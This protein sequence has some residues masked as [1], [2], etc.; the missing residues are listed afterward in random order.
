[1]QLGKVYTEFILPKSTNNRWNS[2][3]QTSSAQDLHTIYILGLQVK[4]SR[5]IVL[6]PYTGL[7]FTYYGYFTNHQVVYF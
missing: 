5:G 3:V 4:Y 2:A 7:K 6:F 1:M